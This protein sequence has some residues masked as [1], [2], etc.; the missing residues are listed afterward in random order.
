MKISV[1][2]DILEVLHGD[3]EGLSSALF[4]TQQ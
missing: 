2:G 3:S 1:F 4:E